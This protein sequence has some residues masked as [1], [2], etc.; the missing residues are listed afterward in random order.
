MTH[1]QGAVRQVRKSPGSL[2]VV[3]LTLRMDMLAVQL[4]RAMML[5]MAPAAAEGRVDVRGLFCH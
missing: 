5:S 1:N 2:K 3:M 4:P